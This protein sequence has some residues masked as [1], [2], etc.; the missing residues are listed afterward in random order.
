MQKYCERW[1]HKLRHHGYKCTAT[2]EIIL[3]I[4]N[5]TDD[6]LSPED[7]Y[8]VAHKN[9]PNIGLTTVYRTLDMLVKLGMVQKFDFGDGRSRYELSEDQ[10]HKKHHHHLICIKCG[11]ILDYSEFI[12]EEL[13]LLKKIEEKLGEK[14]QF[15]IN[16]HIMQFNGVCDQC[17]S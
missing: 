5:S 17:T 3:E 8:M 2:R 6:H 7:I 15:K 9:Y 1:G 11:K 14:Y 10:G 16:D 13:G 12:E 4:L